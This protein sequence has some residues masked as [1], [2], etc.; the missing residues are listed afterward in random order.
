M[1]HAPEQNQNCA[2]LDVFFQQL[3]D[4]RQR[5]LMLDY[6]GTLAPFRIERDQAT[7]Y[8]GVREILNRILDAGQTRVVVVSGRW[9]QEV[10]PLLGLSHPLEIWGSHGWE[11]RQADGGWKIFTMDKQAA[12]GL[13][14]AR[15]WLVSEGLSERAEVKPACL[16]LHWRGLNEAECHRLRAR[17]LSRWTKLARRTGLEI[18]K[19]DGGLELRVPGRNKGLVVQTILSEMDNR[20]AAGYLG[21]DLTDEDAFTA[22]EGR[23]LSALVRQEFRPTRAHIW[24]KPPEELLEFLGRWHHTTGGKP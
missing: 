6:D 13:D 21:D 24:L 15:N 16:A 2:L 23:G 4:A 12:V 3:A 11:H 10:V 22:L 7:P 5:V 8:P 1:N 14:D 19:F 18:N 9:T 20:T 17:V